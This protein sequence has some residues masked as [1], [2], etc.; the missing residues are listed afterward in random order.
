[1]SD[2]DPIRRVFLAR[3]IRE[4]RVRMGLSVAAA[5]RRAGIDR[6]TWAAAEDGEP[7][8]Q[9]S[10]GRIENALSW[11]PGSVLGVLDGTVETPA[12]APAPDDAPP[13]PIVP[14]GTGVD[15]L[16]LSVLA[17]EDRDYLVGL[18]ERL[19]KQRGE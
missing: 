12:E 7:V 8:Q 4:R 2:L 3:S 5:A 19:R 9:F 14:V 16:D 18:Y 10:L 13:D 1:M 6:R 11:L 15:P 17:P